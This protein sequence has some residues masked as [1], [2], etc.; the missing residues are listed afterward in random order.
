MNLF[1]IDGFDHKV[2]IFFDNN[3]YD[4]FIEKFQRA[5]VFIWSHNVDKLK[6]YIKS[7]IDFLKLKF[8]L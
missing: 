5:A 4:F 7:F 3:V 8:Y 1:S 2:A 6:V